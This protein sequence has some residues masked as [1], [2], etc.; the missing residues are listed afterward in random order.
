MKIALYPGSFNPPHLGHEII[1]NE[2]YHQLDLDLV[3]FIPSGIPVNKKHLDNNA[4]HRYNMV[5]ISTESYP[6]IIISDYEVKSKQVNYTFNTVKY[7]V[8]NYKNID[9]LYLITG[10]DWLGKFDSWKNSD[11]LFQKVK[12]ILFKRKNNIDGYKN[13][14]ID[15]EKKYGNKVNIIDRQ[16]DISSSEIRERISKGLVYKHFLNKDV[17][18][19]INQNNL[20]FFKK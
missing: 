6:Y 5:Q 2:V 4:F 8:E 20:Y 7:I 14:I 15:F 12:L 11:E 1:A 18:D 16:F 17:Y 19:Y 3:I 13:K 10:F 9:D